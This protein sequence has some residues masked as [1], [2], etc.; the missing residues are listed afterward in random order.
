MSYY[1]YTYSDNVY[2][3]KPYPDQYY[4]A[5]Y[6]YN[7]INSQSAVASADTGG[8]AVGSLTNRRT[9]LVA[10]ASGGGDC[11]PHV[12]D[13]TLFFL[14]FAAVP[15]AVYA[16]YVAITMNLMRR[17][18]RRKRSETNVNR[19]EINSTGIDSTGINSTG[20]NSTETA[21]TPEPTAHEAEDRIYSAIMI[22]TVL[23]SLI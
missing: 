12:V 7:D 19:T 13:P 18:K 15:V 4:D 8:S 11:C 1:D 14:V 10:A 9:D 6:S 3:R 21:D 17:R 23:N 22:G 2:Q 5:D 20:I 16:V